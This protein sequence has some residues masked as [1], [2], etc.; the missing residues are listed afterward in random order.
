MAGD[1]YGANTAELR[2]VAGRAVREATRIRESELGV[3]SNVMDVE[4]VGPDA[5][6][7]RGEWAET[8]ARMDDL[9]E[10]TLDVARPL[11]RNA[12]EQDAASEGSGTGGGSHGGGRDDGTG[13]SGAVTAEAAAAGSV[14]WGT[15]GADARVG[16]NAFAGLTIELF[17]TEPTPIIGDDV[18]IQPVVDG[19]AGIRARRRRVPRRAG[20]RGRGRR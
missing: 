2:V 17:P 9:A 12:D 19:R 18:T 10:L 4:W 8:A 3:S 5:D 20:G 11:R 7:Y 16:L 1:M 13:K 15:S 6:R 14:R